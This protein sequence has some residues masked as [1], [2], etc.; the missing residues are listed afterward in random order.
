[1]Q[2]EEQRVPFKGFTKPD[3]QLEDH[4]C[5]SDEIINAYRQLKYEQNYSLHDHDLSIDG[6]EFPLDVFTIKRDSHFTDDFICISRLPG[7]RAAIQNY[8]IECK[9]TGQ[10]FV[11]HTLPI[12]QKMKDCPESHN[13]STLMQNLDHFALPRLV[14]QHLMDD[15]MYLIMTNSQAKEDKTLSGVPLHLWVK[16]NRS[17]NSE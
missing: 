7:A 11:C 16:Q 6:Q 12:G 17:Q 3:L 15:R 9:I 14:Q 5:S 4:T 1:M 10:R 13:F 2:L 8:S